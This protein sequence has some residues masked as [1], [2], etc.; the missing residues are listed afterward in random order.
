MLIFQILLGYWVKLFEDLESHILVLLPNKYKM[1]F[2]LGNGTQYYHA[3]LLVYSVAHGVLHSELGSLG[4]RRWN[5]YPGIC[6][7]ISE[8]VMEGSFISRLKRQPRQNHRRIIEVVAEYM[9]TQY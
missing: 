8:T 1:Y 4:K 7:A 5:F 2:F 9:R 6:W 3:L